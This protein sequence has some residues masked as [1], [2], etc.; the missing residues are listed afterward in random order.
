MTPS[1]IFELATVFSVKDDGIISVTVAGMNCQFL[2]DSGAQV[3]TFSERDFIKLKA[4][5]AYRKEIYSYQEKS[6][7]SL[8]PYASGEEIRVL[9]TFEAPLYITNDRPVLLEKFYIV[10]ERYSLLG[11]STS[12]RYCVLLLGLKVPTRDLSFSNESESRDV[13]IA[14]FS[15]SNAF[16]KFNMPPVTIHYDKSAPPCRNIFT[17]VPIALKPLVHQRLM[18]LVKSE[19]IE[20]VD[21]NMNV[22][23]CSS[24][25]VVPKGRDNIRLVIDL[26]GPNRY[27]LRT[28]FAM[29]TLES[30]LAELNGARWFSTIDLSNA[31]FHIE[32]AEE[33][34]HLTNFFTEFGTF[35]CVRLP[36][37]LCNAPDIFQEALER[38][39]LAG[40]HGVRNY[41][42]DVL[43]FGRT[44]EEHDENLKQVMARL[45]DH[46]VKLNDAKC[47]Y[48]RQSVTFIGFKLT[49]DGWEVEGEKINAIRN[50]RKPTTCQEVKS[51]L[52]MVTYIDR[53]LMN[54]AEKTEYLRRL[55]NSDRFYWTIHEEN[56]FESLRDISAYTIQKLGYYSPQDRTELF[57]DASPT[58]LGAMLVQFNDQSV[59]RVIACASKSLTSTEQRYPQTHKEA[60]AVV[61]GVER[62]TT[63]LLSKFFIVRTDSEA[64]EFIF[65]GKYRLGRRAISR[66][67]SWALR[68]QQYDF[69]IQR[70]PGRFNELSNFIIIHIFFAHAI[71]KLNIADALSRL[72]HDSQHAVPFEIDNENH[73]LYSLNSGSMEL[74]WHQIESCS[75]KDDELQSVKEAIETLIWDPSL[76]KYEPHKKE[77]R[78]LGNLLFKDNKVILPQSLRSQ[79]MASAHEGHAGEMAMKRVMREYF[80]W[81]GMS[82]AV[83]RYVKNCETC[84][85]LSKKNPPVPLSSRALP[86][87]PWEII[88]IDFLSLPSCGTGEFLI[89]V[90]T[91]SRYLSVV[92]MKNMDAEST[93]AALCTIFQLWGLPKIMQSDNG[94]PFQGSLFVSSWEDRGVRVRKSI[95]LSPQSNGLVERQNQ[96]LI[97][98]V[99]AAKIEKTSWRNAIQKYVH[100]H[101]TLLPH[102]RLNATPFELLV[103]WKFRGTFPSLW[104]PN[105][106]DRTD[107]REKDAESKLKSKQYA[108]KVRHA[109]DADIKTGDWV[110]LAQQKKYKTDPVFPADRYR[111][112][113]VD[114]PKITIMSK[115]GMQYSRNIQEVKRVP[116]FEIE[117]RPASELVT[118]SDVN[119]AEHDAR[120]GLLSLPN[121]TQDEH[122]S[123]CRDAMPTEDLPSSI[124]LRPRKDLRKP[125]RF[126]EKFVY[127][128]I[129]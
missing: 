36:F 115:N 21:E 47:C 122:L 69:R 98:A 106:L 73:F 123:D 10:N 84:I 50:F 59:P 53:F 20:P 44:E 80:W 2:I 49:A 37:G 32:L 3:N 25:L 9:G 126:N 83:E 85:R 57:V 64:N 22:S 55:A 109:M 13:R 67:E 26:R 23:F 116:E 112:I 56:E 99:A 58:G 93:N 61:W 28:P 94:P 105:R 39:V 7:R 101:N 48:K 113:A 117:E 91:Y 90:D 63:Y 75:E 95:P 60:L 82:T 119:I 27:I 24:M 108:D 15:T 129:H 104:S 77:L 92:E 114:G 88:Q 52:G 68:L 97:K 43:V 4:N 70:V 14:A 81:P 111:V 79:A 78:F 124:N 5:E 103:G 12:I 6:D 74:T 72:V 107:I 110:F 18:E 127:T 62:F 40:C 87:G 42:D 35:R 71:G 51:F 66:S 29:P 34:R 96:G 30:I 31:F 8:K 38:K 33:S 19:I 100:H 89:V 121:P 11:R 1:D 86:D 125:W 118:C 45:K 17:N 128:V 54:R 102:S 16:P 46:N 76:V 65:N 120:S 41:L